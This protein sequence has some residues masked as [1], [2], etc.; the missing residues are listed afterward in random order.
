MSVNDE[1]ARKS[2]ESS[3]TT[4]V[5]TGTNK[6]GHSREPSNSESNVIS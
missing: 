2:P 6:D 5:L 1:T 3:A 4:E